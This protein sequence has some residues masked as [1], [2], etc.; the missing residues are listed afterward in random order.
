MR[1]KGG[2]C[3]TRAVRTAARHAELSLAWCLSAAGG[4]GSGKACS[5]FHAESSGG[6]VLPSAG[7]IKKSCG[8]RG[9]AGR[10]PSCSQANCLE[11]WAASCGTA[12]N[13]KSAS[14]MKTVEKVCAPHLFGCPFIA[15][16]EPRGVPRVNDG[17]SSGLGR[18]ALVCL[19]TATLRRL[20]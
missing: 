18:R 5:T 17:A 2:C 19:A 16:P 14:R 8:H 13:G 10:R 4:A 12:A 1:L 6:R 7:R 15:S 20:R 9:S 11:T 3:S